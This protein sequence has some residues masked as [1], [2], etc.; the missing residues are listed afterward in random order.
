MSG[1][2]GTRGERTASLLVVPWQPESVS[3]GE[4]MDNSKKYLILAIALMAILVMSVAC[5]P[6]GGSAPVE[7]SPL[8]DALSNGRPTLAGFVGDECACKDMR[9]TLEELAADYSGRCNIV[10][11]DAM[12]YKDLAGEHEIILTPTLL[13]FD[14]SGQEVTRHIGYWPMEEVVAQLEAIGVA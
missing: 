3:D 9:P 1:S 14:G 10:I 5:S 13:L 12:D 4:D 11:I 2:R 8:N 6:S 7:T